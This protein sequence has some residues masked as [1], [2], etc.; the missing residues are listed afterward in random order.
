MLNVNVGQIE[1]QHVE[2]TVKL[3]GEQVMPKFRDT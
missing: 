3:F 1:A 2:R